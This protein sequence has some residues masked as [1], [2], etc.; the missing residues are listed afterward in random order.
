LPGNGSAHPTPPPNVANRKKQISSIMTLAA[1]LTVVVRL[2]SP[3]GM[4]GLPDVKIAI[5]C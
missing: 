2:I 5:A 3:G 1:F 4:P